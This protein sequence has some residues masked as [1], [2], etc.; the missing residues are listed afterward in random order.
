MR[1]DDGGVGEVAGERAQGNEEQRRVDGKENIGNSIR[2]GATSRA[3]EYISS[4]S[5]GSKRRGEN[6]RREKEKETNRLQ[7]LLRD[8]FETFHFSFC[9]PLLRP[10]FRFFSR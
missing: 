5:I 9:S 8:S 7:R 10:C 4:S 1:T 2:S 3:P 6:K